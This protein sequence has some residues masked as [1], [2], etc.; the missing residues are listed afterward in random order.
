M[1]NFEKLK[2]MEI[3]ELADNLDEVFACEYCPITE[4]CNKNEK[5]KKCKSIWK[6]W[7]KSE[8]VEKKNLKVKELRK[9]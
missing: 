7:L 2:N 3:D 6:K 4:F 5:I 1:T 8:S 9:F